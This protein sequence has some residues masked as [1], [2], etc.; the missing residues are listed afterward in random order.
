MSDST[1]FLERPTADV[2]A[3]A[4]PNPARAFF[5]RYYLQLVLV[6]AVVLLAIAVPAFRSPL[7]V[8]NVLLQS[9][10][11]GLVACGMTLLIAAGLFDLS[12]AGVIALCGVAVATVLPSTTIGMAIGATLLL[13]ASLG[14]LNGVVV[15]KIRIPA[16]IATLGMLNL[17]LAAAF[18]WTSGEVIPIASYNFLSIVTATVF[19]I[20]VMFLIFVL[21][22]VLSHLL[23]HKSYFGRRLRG[24]GSSEPAATMAGYRVDRVKIVAFTLTGLFSAIAAIGLSGLL[25]SANATMATGYELN[26]IAIAVV[27]GTA[28]RGGEGTLLGTF[29]G[30]LIFAVLGNALNLLRVDPYWQ[31]LAVGLV[32][33]AAIAAGA[34]R[35]TGHVRGVS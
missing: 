18:I 23:L 29:T 19:G 11:A 13:G 17:Y 34:L 14:A 25:S 8:Q 28:L 16:F 30:A 32:L 1:S 5:G 24:I 9:S 21:V 35:K 10:F 4:R 6:A 12:V 2:P 31:Y 15:T 27:G 22:C 7:N 3:V 20:P 33:V 26:A